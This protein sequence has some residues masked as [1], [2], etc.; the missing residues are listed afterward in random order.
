MNFI[1]KS[2]IAVAISAS[3][4]V[5]AA[6]EF[7]VH[8]APGGPSDRVTRLITKYLPSDYVVVN[9]PGAGGRI[10]VKHLI[11]ENTLM[12]ATVSQIFVTN[13]LTT[14]G[15][16]YDP[17]R[18]LEILGTAA[19]MPNVLA[20]KSSL[21]FKDIKDLNNRQLNF[22]VAGYG[23]SEHIATEALFTKI[24]GNHQSVPYAQGGAA[25]VTD[26]LAGNLDCMFANYPTIKPFIEDRRITVL[27]SSHEL[28]LN[29]STWREQFGEPFPFQSYLSIVISK[30]MP[31]AD[32]RKILEDVASVFENTEFKSELKALG[33]FTVTRTDSAS[34]DQVE[35]AN[36]ALFKFL[37]NSKIKLQ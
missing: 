34:V 9:R 30:Q 4:V 2:L 15:A 3:A 27:F 20:C 36:A 6:T 37:V 18:D 24:T 35:R 5:A 1:K 17:I 22:G 21:G 10:A 11:K 16:G 29:V 26:L 12:L 28:G 31:G 33:L 19:A 7:T 23:S 13:L 25:G 32:R 8:H 14:Q